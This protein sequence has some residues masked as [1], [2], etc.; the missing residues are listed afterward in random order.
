MK[1]YIWFDVERFVRT[2]SR[3]SRHKPIT[4]HTLLEDDLGITSDRAGD[5][6]DR[7]FLRFEVDPGD[8][9]TDRYFRDGAS[10]LRLLLALFTGRRSEERR[11][12]PLTVGMLASAARQGR[13]ESL[14]LEA[15]D[16]K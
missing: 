16:R 12:V 14:K 13:W 15:L 6:M 11:R 5:F 2:E 9:R 8:Y 3:A 10:G 1:A 7:F 4:P